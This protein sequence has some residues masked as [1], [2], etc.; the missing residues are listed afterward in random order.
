MSTAE[1]LTRMRVIAAAVDVADRRGLSGLTMRSVAKALSS[2]PMAL[3]HH[4]R[5]KEDL[6]DGMIDW[7]F[8]QI[9]PVDPLA[10]WKP[11][12]RQHAMAARTV[13][14]RHPWAVAVIDSR[15]PPGPAA[16]RHHENVLALLVRCGFTL[17]TAALAYTMLDAYVYGFVMQD[18]AIEPSAETVREPT[19]AAP[20]AASHPHLA[21]F[22]S[23]FAYS[24]TWTFADQFEPGLDLILSG[25]AGSAES[26]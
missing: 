2:S 13:L 3:Y 10:P 26:P 12:L 15:F 24:G 19:F 5:G 23:R 9:D 4:V 18:Q 14:T 20:L 25:I 1:R 8:E 17:E 21:Q 16:M 7:L 6:L 11:Q 22:A